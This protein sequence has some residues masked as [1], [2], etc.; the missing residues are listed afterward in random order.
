MMTT[1]TMAMFGCDNDSD[2]DDCGHC[3]DGCSNNNCTLVNGDNDNRQKGASSS[4]YIVVLNL[5]TISRTIFNKN[6][7]LR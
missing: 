1:T 6:L 5:V 4:R 7:K 3:G 2:N